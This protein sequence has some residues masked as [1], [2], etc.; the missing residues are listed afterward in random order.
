[1]GS[2]AYRV[3]TPDSDYDFYGFCIPPKNMVF[4]HLAGEIPG[5]STTTKRFEQWLQTGIEFNKKD[6]DFQVFSIVKY[7][8][9]LMD[10][11]PN[12]LESIYTDQDCVQHCTQIGNIVRENRKLFLHKG[13]WPKLKGYAYSQLHKMTSTE[14]IGKR[15]DEVTDYGYDRKFA[16][17]VIRLLD[18]AECILTTNDLILGRNKEQLKA[19]R[20][21]EV[22]A[23]EIKSIAAEKERYLEELYHK[24]TDLPYE[25]NESKIK[26]LLLHCLE[27]HY[28]SLENCITET[29]WE[30]N[31][32]K[33][34]KEIID[35]VSPKL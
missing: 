22:S 7:F 30:I 1:M 21:G 17:H 33:S 2:H 12:M 25:P 15:K 9:L 10:N 13:C 26:A 27:H 28:G 35:K 19:I 18:Q 11:N 20:R 34:I 31:T 4:P 16:Y 24:N 29:G 23:E 32:L 6:Y 5:F 3:N 14:R 8:R